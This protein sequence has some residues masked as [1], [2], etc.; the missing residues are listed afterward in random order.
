MEF[1]AKRWIVALVGCA[2]LAGVPACDFETNAASLTLI[3][4]IV[5]DETCTVKTGGG[6]QQAFL[7]SGVLDLSVGNSYWMF[8]MFSN[9]F[10]SAETL[11]TFK[12]TDLRI[13]PA[14]VTIDRVDLQVSFP[15]ELINAEMQVAMEELG[16]PLSAPPWSFVRGA[17][18]TTQPGSQGVVIV[19]ILPSKVGQ[20]FRYM[21]QLQEGFGVQITVRIQISGF[22][23]D[24]DRVKSSVLKYPIVLCNHCRVFHDVSIPEASQPVEPT[25]AAESGGTQLSFTMPCS[26]G[27]D[28]YMSV[29]GCGFLYGP[30]VTSDTCPLQRCLGPQNPTAPPILHCDNY[31]SYTVGAG[32]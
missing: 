8:L 6:G 11:S 21:E 3:G 13:D 16:L 19:D 7:T 32:L 10:Q 23:M 26:P 4:S 18:V 5:P 12:P 30:H 22:R 27:Q 20:V 24:G 17:A 9:N 25:G 28:D 14:T 2:L 15:A 1:L 31:D 29:V